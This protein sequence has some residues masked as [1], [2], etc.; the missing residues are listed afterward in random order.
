[1]LQALLAYHIDALVPPTQH[2]TTAS[3]APQRLNGN[4]E[5]HFFSVGNVL[6]RTLVIYMRKKGVSTIYWTRLTFEAYKQQT[7]S[8][9]HALEPVIDK[10]NERPKEPTGRFGLFRSHKSE[11]FKH[12]KEF[13][14]PTESYDLIFMKAKI[15]ILCTKGFEIMDIHK[16]AFT[17][18]G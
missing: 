13:T 14:L 5:V 6:G 11:W 15:A 4:K 9:F 12:F 3:Q 17:A 16:Y 8:H 2:T 18:L 10:I 1:L 7:G